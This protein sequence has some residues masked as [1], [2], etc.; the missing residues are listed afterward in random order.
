M[1]FCQKV[2]FEILSIADL[3]LLKKKKKKKKKKIRWD[4]RDKTFSRTPEMQI[5]SKYV[6]LFVNYDIIVYF[7]NDIELLVSLP[8]SWLLIIINVTFPTMHYD[9]YR[10]LTRTHRAWEYLK[11]AFDERYY[12]M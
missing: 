9:F 7:L 10:N 2:H 3:T 8:V 12:A 4:I 5:D 11:F 1:K 6:H